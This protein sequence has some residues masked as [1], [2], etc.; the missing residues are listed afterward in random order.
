VEIAEALGARDDP[1][2]YFGK[3]LSLRENLQVKKAVMLFGLYQDWDDWAQGNALYARHG[4][5]RFGR[6]EEPGWP[7]N[8]PIYRPP[9]YEGT[10]DTDPRFAIIARARFPGLDP[11]VVCTHLTT[12]YGERGGELREIPGKSNEAQMLR[13]QQAKI[14]LELLRPKMEER[15]VIL[16]MGDFNAGSQ[17]ACISSVLEREGKFIRL[18]PRQDIPTHMPDHPKVPNAVDHILVYPRERVKAY[19]CWIDNSDE[20][21]GASDHLPVVADITFN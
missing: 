4:F 13:F 2:Y 7:R 6:P 21:R 3:T 19:S 17:E 11:Y 14:L 12:L 9:V 18:V 15:K 8:V 16:L 5:V 1:S 10:R 20:A